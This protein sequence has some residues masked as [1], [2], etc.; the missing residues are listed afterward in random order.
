[1]KKILSKKDLN[2]LA[3]VDSQA[4]VEV[5]DFV[6]RLENSIK[7]VF[8]DSFIQVQYRPSMGSRSI[9]VRFALGKDKSE[10]ANGIIQ[11]DPLFHVMWIYGIN[12]DGSLKDKMKMEAHSGGRLILKET[13]ETGF[14]NKLVKLGFR[15]MTGVPDKIVK[16]VGN[17]LKKAKNI[18]KQ[19]E[20][21]LRDQGFPK[22]KV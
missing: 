20:D 21:Q 17:Y 10:W 1:M 14:R 19:Y 18:F 8:P 9:L 6:K 2:Y 15:S 4:A 7:S 11:N 3:S 5:E 16:G 13:D 22:D 12:E